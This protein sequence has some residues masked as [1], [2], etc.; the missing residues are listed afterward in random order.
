MIITITVAEIPTGAIADL[1][2]KK[3]TLSLAFL[4]TSIGELIMANAQNL[5]MIIGSVIIIVIGAALFSGTL[6]ALLYDS[7]KQTGKIFH[8]P[9]SLGL[10]ASLRYFAIAAASIIGGY[11]FSVNP[12]FPFYATAMAELVAFILTFFLTEPHIDTE[13]FSLRNYFKQTKQGFVELFQNH[14]TTTMSLSLLSVGAFFVILWE[15]VNDTLALNTRLSPSGLGIFFSIAY[16]ATSAA[17]QLFPRLPVRIQSIFS[18]LWIS[19][20]SA[21]TLV[22]SPILAPI[23]IGIGVVLRSIAFPFHHLVTSTTVNSI[24]SSKNR[25]TTISTFNMIQNLP[26]VITAF[27]I[28]SLIDR[29]SAVKFAFGLGLVMATIVIPQLLWK[30]IRP[31]QQ[32][33]PR[34]PQNHI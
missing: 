15:S 23:G 5:P 16:L 29:F 2:G 22:I 11:L 21:I 8:Y 13:K 20:I 1:L 9:K 26:Y 14:H 7:L 33:Q 3:R 30:L 34:R 25:A 17:S 18:V 32:T 6:E 10:T 4:F 12:R 27:F 28:G 24:A 31:A 19:L